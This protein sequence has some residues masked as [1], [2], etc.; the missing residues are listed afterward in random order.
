M[1][2]EEF[3]MTFTE[4]ITETFHV[5]SCYSCSVR[6]GITGYLY[7]R[8]VTDACDSIYCPA[9]GKL[10]C[11]SESEDSKIIKEL[12]RKLK[13][14]AAEVTRQ[15]LAR[16]KAEASLQ[17]TKGVITRIK[18]RVGSGVCPCCQRTFKQLSAHMAHK[19]PEYASDKEPK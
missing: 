5:V 17:A 4:H 3:K 15:K 14:E 18:R 6:F 9:C 13:W 11:W 7:K 16:E 1:E 12:Q 8:V 10:T 2:G 19:H